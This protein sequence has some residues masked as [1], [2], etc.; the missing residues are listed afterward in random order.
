MPPPPSSQLPTVSIWVPPAPPPPRCSAPSSWSCSPSPPSSSSSDRCGSANATSPKPKGY[1]SQVPSGV[2][3]M[4]RSVSR[5]SRSRSGIFRVEDRSSSK[6]SLVLHNRPAQRSDTA[7]ERLQRSHAWA[8]ASACSSGTGRDRR[9]MWPSALLSKIDSCRGRR[10]E[11][12]ALTSPVVGGGGGGAPSRMAPGSSTPA[13]AATAAADNGPALG[14][15]TAAAPGASGPAARRT[16]A[17]A[18]DHSSPRCGTAANPL[19]P[20][21]SPTGAR[22]GSPADAMG[23]EGVSSS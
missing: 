3:T 14:V 1:F 21:P 7:Q 15:A 19:W 22:R 17:E 9:P 5:P 4:A 16:E 11:T 13:P 18:S 12:S 8:A 6:S 20:T 2:S 10:S 23:A